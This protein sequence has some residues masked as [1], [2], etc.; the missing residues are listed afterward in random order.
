MLDKVDILMASYNSSEYILDQLQSII[1]Q[2]Y[3]NY[4][5]IIRDDCSHD[6]TVRLIEEF[7][8]KRPG[9]IFLIKG[10]E[11]LGALGNFSA[12][13]NY[14]E[15]DYTMFSDA[16]DIWLPNKIE[17]CLSVMKKNEEMYGKE[18]PLLVHTDLSVVDRNLKILN[19]SF[20]DYSKLK[21]HRI[22]SLNRLLAHNVVTGCTMLINRPLLQLARPIPKEAIMHDWWLGLVASAFGHIDLIEKPTILYRQHGKN[23]TG[24]KNWKKMSTILSYAK[25]ASQQLG[26]KE[27]HNRLSK[28]ICQ[29]SHFLK[30]YEEQLAIHNKSIVQNYVA[31]GTANPFQKRVLFLKNRFFKNTFAKNIGMFLFL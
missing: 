27:L 18:I 30:R 16:D 2:T 11:N 1:E 20:W 23:D 24:A 4:R 29:A 21:P 7:S 10:T 15:A 13:L 8:N 31:L 6:N 25:K 9:K 22:K 28:T 19:R 5:I 17:E 26:R 14:S 12:L 3:S